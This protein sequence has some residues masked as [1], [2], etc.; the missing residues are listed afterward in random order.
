MD[1]TRGRTPFSRSGRRVTL[2][3]NP[4]WQQPGSVPLPNL[5]TGNPWPAPTTGFG[6]DHT[7]Q[8]PEEPFVAVNPFEQKRRWGRASRP[9]HQPPAP[10]VPGEPVPLPGPS[11]Y[12]A[13]VPMST[14]PPAPQFSFSNNAGSPEARHG[15]E[16]VARPHTAPEPHPPTVVEIP[17]PDMSRRSRWSSRSHHARVPSRR[18]PTPSPPA[19]APRVESPQTEAGSLAGSVVSEP[20]L[21][22]PGA[23]ILR[24]RSSHSRSS[25]DSYPRPGRGRSGR[26]SRTPPRSRSRSNSRHEGPGE[27]VPIPSGHLARRHSGSRSRS[28]SRESRSPNVDPSTGEEPAM[29]ARPHRR[30]SRSPRSRSPSSRRSSRS[31]SRSRSPR[32][33]RHSYQHGRNNPF[34]PPPVVPPLPPVVPPLPPFVP[35]MWNAN[36]PQV[37]PN[38]TI[39]T[40]PAAGMKYEPEASFSSLPPPV[41]ASTTLA[42]SFGDTIQDIIFSALIFILDVIPRQLYLHFL[43]RIPSMYFTRVTRIF[44]DA[45]LSLPDIKKM[46][47]ARAEQWNPAEPE[48]PRWPTTFMQQLPN[49]NTEPLP[50]SLLVFRSNWDNFIDDLMSE[51]Q[52]LNIVSVLLMSAILTMLQIDSA[53]HPIIRTSALFSLICALMSLLYGCVYIIRFGSM[54]KMYKASS[55]AE[56]LYSFFSG[57]FYSMRTQEA[58]KSTTSIWAMILFFVCIM[59]FVWLTGSTNSPTDV[60]LSPRAALGVRIALTAVF[61]LG[62]I[63]FVLIVQTFH[64]YGDPLDREWMRRVNEWSREV[65]ATPYVYGQ[66]APPPPPPPPM[67]PVYVQSQVVRVPPSPSSSRQSFVPRSVTPEMGHRDR[68]RSVPV[69]PTDA[70]RMPQPPPVPPQSSVPASQQPSGDEEPFNLMRLGY[71][72]VEASL[73]TPPWVETVDTEDLRRFVVDISSAWHRRLALGNGEGEVEDVDL[74]PLS[75]PD[76]PSPDQAGQEEPVTPSEDSSSSH[77]R[78]RPSN[79]LVIFSP[80]PS[81]DHGTSL[82]LKSRRPSPESPYI[83]YPSPPSWSTL[84]GPNNIHEFIALWNERYFHLRGM[85]VS[86]V[87]PDDGGPGYVVSLGRRRAGFALGSTDVQLI[88]M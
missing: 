62:L 48:N 13:G 43:L 68:T 56:V 6:W 58:Q 51:W 75:L 30:L 8:Y 24:H 16:N 63:Y 49:V 37:Q 25:Q 7:P 34:V 83:Q 72:D 23:L 45:Q 77:G 27:L 4:A 71:N 74:A 32:P 67:Q 84:T 19:S 11:Q 12:P 47:R 81:N 41:T 29:V 9:N 38:P 35:P 70:P 52:T 66:T 10:F 5:P 79:A 20:P 17:R 42:N 39:P 78:V 44:E 88:A 80:P 55:F 31:P 14:V 64:R 33:P 22:Q 86:L 65:W 61:S 59:S 87:P 50:R 82:V 3:D 15:W 28:G 1:R 69:E 21:V 36:M 57:H 46:A 73:L 53:S 26:G 18:S 76:V 2:D 40:F 60:V 85:Q 54:R